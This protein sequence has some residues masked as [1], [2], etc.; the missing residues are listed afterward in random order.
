MMNKRIRVNPDETYNSLHRLDFVRTYVNHLVPALKKINMEK[1]SSSFCLC[2]D[3]NGDNEL[4]K[5]VRFEVDMAMALSAKEFYFAWSRALEAR[6]IQRDISLNIIKFGGNNYNN[7]NNSNNSIIERGS[8]FHEISFTNIDKSGESN[9]ALLASPNPRSCEMMMKKKRKTSTSRARK[10]VAKKSEEDIIV[11]DR[12][13]RLRT[14]L[15]G[16]NDILGDSDNHQLLTEVASYIACL[17]LQV[18]AL[19]SLVELSHE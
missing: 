18:N 2:N 15:P 14:L 6:L 8:S 9:S 11:G 3:R 19:K 10:G 5:A 13:G 17:Q 16:G 12:F 4:A 7:N 1:S